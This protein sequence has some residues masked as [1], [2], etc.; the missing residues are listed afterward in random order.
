MSLTLSVCPLSIL[1]DLNGGSCLFVGL[2]SYHAVVCAGIRATTFSVIHI[3]LQAMNA[4]SLIP[5]L[6]WAHNTLFVPI[7]VLG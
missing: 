6:R 2:I 7:G 1:Y 3:R 5:Q 4:R